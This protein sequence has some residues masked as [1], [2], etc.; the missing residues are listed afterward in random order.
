MPLSTYFPAQYNYLFNF[1]QFLQASVYWKS[2]APV[3]NNV[4][5]WKQHEHQH[6]FLGGR[7][8][9]IAKADDGATV[10]KSVCHMTRNTCE[11]ERLLE[12]NMYTRVVSSS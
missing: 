1:I 12:C 7:A 5:S 2:C 8:P 11:Y 9:R 10:F 6:M 3:T 4:T